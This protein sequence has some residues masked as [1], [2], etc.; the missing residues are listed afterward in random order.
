MGTSLSDIKSN[1]YDKKYQ[2]V[3]AR[4]TFT[5]ARGNRL[6]AY[7]LEKSWEKGSK[8][9]QPEPGGEV[10]TVET[11]EG[12]KEHLVYLDAKGGRKQKMLWSLLSGEIS[13]PS[14]SRQKTLK[15]G[16]HFPEKR[17]TGLSSIN[18]N[19][20]AET[21]KSVLTPFPTLLEPGTGTG[22]SRVTG[23]KKGSNRPRQ[24]VAVGGLSNVIQ[25]GTRR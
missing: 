22:F 2:P 8:A 19:S 16:S 24:R 10:V 23:R 6:C 14:S 1:G 11:N 12:G 15:T 7:G 20:R 21:N 5:L 13:G 18:S 9:P 17:G 4:R 3:P 25:G